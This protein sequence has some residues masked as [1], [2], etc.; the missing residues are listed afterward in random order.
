MQ[1]FM[2]IA[3]GESIWVDPNTVKF[4][5]IVIGKIVTHDNSAIYYF[6]SL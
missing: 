5:G 4:K 2:S 3:E 1:L 6:V